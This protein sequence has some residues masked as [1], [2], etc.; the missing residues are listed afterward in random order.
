MMKPFGRVLCQ[1]KA[2]NSNQEEHQ[3]SRS[4]RQEERALSLTRP[5]R[6]ALRRS[7]GW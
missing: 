7:G 2:G 1:Y 3:E 6:L 4:R 5:R